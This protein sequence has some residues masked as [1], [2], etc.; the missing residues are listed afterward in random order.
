MR[1]EKDTDLYR[2]IGLNIKNYRKQA[3]ISQAK[4]AEDIGLSL[5]YISKIEA[6]GCDKSFSISTLNSIANA[7]NVDIINFFEEKIND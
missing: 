4:L 1:F 6:S 3:N 2:T 5:S 7:L